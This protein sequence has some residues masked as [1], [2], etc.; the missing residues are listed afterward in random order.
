MWIFSLTSRQDRGIYI[1]LDVYDFLE[2]HTFLQLCNVPLC[3]WALVPSISPHT[4]NNHQ[5][6]IS[7]HNFLGDSLLSSRLSSSPF[8]LSSFSLLI[9]SSSTFLVLSSMSSSASWRFDVIIL[10]F[11]SSPSSLWLVFS[12]YLLISTLFSL[13]LAWI[14]LD[15]SSEEII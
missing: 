10:I 12:N 7:F 13:V 3:P 5:H 15:F 6:P 4:S 2:V 8:P 9:I 11:K 14:I 1:F